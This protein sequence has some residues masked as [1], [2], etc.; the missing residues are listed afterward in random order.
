M[1][2]FLRFKGAPL[3][4]PPDGPPGPHAGHA[5]CSGRSR[6]AV[7]S[8]RP[9]PQGNLHHQGEDST[10]HS[11]KSLSEKCLLFLRHRGH[12]SSVEQARI[13]LFPQV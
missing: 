7:R 5:A 10:R 6:R 4:G 8:T 13:L 12:G 9:R 1:R 11:Q 3:R 2:T